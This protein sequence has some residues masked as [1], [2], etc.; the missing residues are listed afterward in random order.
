MSE[1]TTSPIMRTI[2]VRCSAE[3]AFRVFT[4]EMTTWWPLETHSRALDEDKNVKAEKVVF[5]GREGDRVYE[6]MSDGAEGNWA[7]VLAWDP[8]H[9]VVLAWKPNDRPA[10]QHTEL[11]VRFSPDGDGTRVDL[12]HL[13]WERLGPDAEEAREGYASGWPR[14]FD[15]LYAAAANGDA[16]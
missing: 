1:Q 13:G 2:T 4:E 11:E 16:A 15:E 8:P 6:V 9:R 14:V 5:E 3:R 12:E 10:E 7:T